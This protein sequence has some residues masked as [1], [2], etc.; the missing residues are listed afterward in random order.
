MEEILNSIINGQRKQALE[1]L[2]ESPYHLEDVFL[3][4]DKEEIIKLYRVAL[5]TGYIVFGETE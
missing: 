4:L 5:Y 2:K 3:E 1:L